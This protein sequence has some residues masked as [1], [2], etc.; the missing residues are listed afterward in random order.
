MEYLLLFPCIV[1]FLLVVL[2]MPS[3]IK[4]A[5]AIGLVWDDMNKFKKE[6]VAGSGGVIVLLSFCTGAFFFIAYRVFYL[7]T[8]DFLVEML[9][10]ILVVVFA[11]IV[12]FVDDLIGWRRGGLT[13]ISRIVLIALAAIPL[14]AINAG[15]HISSLPFLGEVD[16][17]IM[18]PLLL[19]PIGVIGATTTF[20]F[21]AGFNGLESGQGVIL[22][23]GLALVSFLTGNTPLALIALCMA[24]AL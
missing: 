13:R 15:R 18:Y 17:S 22:L 24:S 23:S 10:L 5:H 2:L 16:L 8:S 12:G 20:N 7:Q 21:L 19:I 4:K 6:K 9:A 3:W 11:A 1:S 14:M